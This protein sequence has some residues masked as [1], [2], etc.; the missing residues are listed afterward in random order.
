M[1]GSR[2]TEHLDLWIGAEKASR[3]IEDPSG[4]EGQI[5]RVAIRWKSL[6]Q[7][8]TVLMRQG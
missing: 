1:P 8:P 5:L 3:A 7:L 4:E 2:L 6:V